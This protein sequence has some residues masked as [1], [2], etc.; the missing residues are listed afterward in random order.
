MSVSGVRLLTLN[1]CI[2][3]L[4]LASLLLVGV[5]LVGCSA[6]PA[7]TS[8][9]PASPPTPGALRVMTWNVQTGEHDPA[10]WVDV[11]ARLRP[12]VVGLQEICADE[13]RELADRLRARGLD[14]TAVPGPVRPAG[15]EATAPINA[16]LGPAC[17][18][19]PDAVAF[20]LGVLSRFPV[21][22]PAVTLFPPDR[23]DEQRGYLTVRVALPDR[24]VLTVVTTHLGLDGVADDQLRLLADA[25]ARDDPAVVLGD[26][27][28]DVDDPALAP[29]SR[30]FTELDP[31]GRATTAFG[32]LDHVFVRGLRVEGGSEVGDVDVSDHRPLVGVLTPR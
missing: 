29:L 24:R 15:A 28:V 7:P 13:V 9:A 1:V 22:D 12:D 5:V 23:R 18:T 6:A 26:L 30:A 2:G 3:T 19:A 27:N 10:D 17:G 21:T 4:T 14:Y 8:R 32:R 31:D 16:A 20:G 11:V 25:T